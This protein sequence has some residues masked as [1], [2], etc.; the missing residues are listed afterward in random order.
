IRRRLEHRRL[1]AN[2]G[3]A[4]ELASAIP[5]SD[6]VIATHTPTMPVVLA[7]CALLRRGRPLWLCQ[8]YPEMF[9]G[10][11][12]ERAIFHWAPRAFDA[13][14][15]ISDVTAIDAWRGGQRNVVVVGE[16]LGEWWRHLARAPAARDP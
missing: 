6:F 2:L 11:P 9:D 4:I 8:D 3:L 12:V 16:G 1:R 10:R 15:C 7:A 5:P 13:A 14:L